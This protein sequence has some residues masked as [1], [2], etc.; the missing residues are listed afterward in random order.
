MSKGQDYLTELNRS[1][2]R[3]VCWIY[4][5]HLFSNSIRL[6]SLS[7][8]HLHIL[9]YGSIISMQWSLHGKPEEWT[10]SEQ[11]GMWSFLSVVHSQR[12]CENSAPLH[13]RPHLILIFICILCNILYNNPVNVSTWAVWIPKQIK[14]KTSLC[15]EFIIGQY[16]KIKLS[17]A[18]NWLCLCM[19]EKTLADQSRL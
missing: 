10:A 7:K 15:K 19:C 9:A 4:L 14:S 3:Q 8:S 12:G 2:H 16:V 1:V 11:Q 13:F 18:C 5:F 6:Y 17:G